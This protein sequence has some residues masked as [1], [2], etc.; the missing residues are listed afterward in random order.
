V[1]LDFFAL[2]SDFE[3]LCQFIWQETDCRI[4]ESYSR[5]DHELRWFDFFE[6]LEVTFRYP[7]V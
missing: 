2:R 7:S 1:K 5:Y 6:E 3:Q 4:A